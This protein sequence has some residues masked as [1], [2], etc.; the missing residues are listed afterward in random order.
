[1]IY[2]PSEDEDEGLYAEY[3]VPIHDTSVDSV[4]SLTEPLQEATAR[5][6]NH[7]SLQSPSPPPTHSHNAPRSPSPPSVQQPA[8]PT[9][10]SPKQPSPA[11]THTPSPANS[12]Q[13]TPAQDVPVSLP[14]VVLQPN[15]RPR[16]PVVHMDL[17][18]SEDDEDD[19]VSVFRELSQ[20]PEMDSE[21]EAEGRNFLERSF[22][23]VHLTSSPNPFS[24]SPAVR[25]QISRVQAAKE[26]LMASVEKSSPGYSPVEL[27]LADNAGDDEGDSGELDVEPNVVKITSDDPLAAARA[28]AILRLH[29]YNSIDESTLRKRRHSNP[30][31]DAILRSARKKVTS[32]SGVTKTTPRRK[33]P[34]GRV[35]GNK[36]FI[37]GSPAMTLPELLDQEEVSLQIDD[38]SLHH[39][40][41][42]SVSFASDFNTPVKQV[43]PSYDQFAPS[44]APSVGP[45]EWNKKDWKTLDAC[46]TDERLALGERLELGVDELAPAD[47]VELENVVE[48][49]IDIMGGDDALQQLGSSWTRDDLLRRARALQRKQRSG[50]YAAPT[51]SRQSSVFSTD[52]NFGRYLSPR[53]ASISSDATACHRGSVGSLSPSPPPS[54]RYDK[55][56]DEA[57][58]VMSGERR[59]TSPGPRPPPTNIGSPSL[60][61]RMKGFIFSY[62]PR[63]SKPKPNP[64]SSVLGKGL[65]VPPPEVFNK[66][67][68]PI[69]T[70]APKPKPRPAHPKE[71]VNLAP[72]PK[73]SMIPR[74]TKQ[75]RRL[76]D[77]NHVTPPAPKTK[78]M[79]PAGRR[80]SGASV[81]DLV[82]T[83][84]GRS[85]EDISIERESLSRLGNRRVE[86][87]A[88]SRLPI[89]KATWKP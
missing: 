46:Y 84:E 26:K 41:L 4:A 55:L 21:D 5:S 15:E 2:L 83:F 75:Y 9:P 43:I 53:P 29:R 31:V 85:R 8:S 71:L 52:S 27:S 20:P 14:P 32:E 38:H 82:Q 61:S 88:G 50:N 22:A 59:D 48:R 17:D 6:S 70:P 81:K 74:P 44:P 64:Q 23:Q 78:P 16:S 80:D 87:W 45:R 66:P 67:R 35:V 36:V 79:M 37:P 47:N 12:R 49:F 40:P 58:A 7:H 42:R 33:H 60:A 51:P 19:E 13:P 76:V 30:A 57:V 62:L 34:L 24:Q 56:I 69:T 86:N 73:P 11:P 1:M 65:P 77:L 54:V 68:P 39:S 28:A 72:A 10:P 63:M 25:P 3:T 18:D 89:Q